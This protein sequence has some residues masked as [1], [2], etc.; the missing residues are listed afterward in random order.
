MTDSTCLYR[1]DWLSNSRVQNCNL[2]G[3]QEPVM[4]QP[5]LAPG[6]G[7]GLGSTGGQERL[8]PTLSSTPG[9][10]TDHPPLKETSK[11]EMAVSGRAAEL[12]GALLWG[13]GP[14]ARC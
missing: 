2:L 6:R 1:K 12:S 4:S 9:T 7:S 14:Q 3:T 11:R 5:S 13:Q 8:V 10:S